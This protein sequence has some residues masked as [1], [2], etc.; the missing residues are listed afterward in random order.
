MYK[1]V[2]EGN[3]HQK[4]ILDRDLSRRKQVKEHHVWGEQSV[5]WRFVNPGK[6][7]QEKYYFDL[8]KPRDPKDRLKRI[9]SNRA[10]DEQFYEKEKDINKISIPQNKILKF[11]KL[12]FVRNN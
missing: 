12:Q 8:V 10:F 9:S 7:A 1:N 3:Y 5:L 4:T 11:L 2:P 6:A